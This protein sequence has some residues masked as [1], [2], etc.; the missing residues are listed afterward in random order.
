MQSDDHTVSLSTKHNP[1]CGL[2]CSFT[3]SLLLK[4][5]LTRPAMLTHLSQCKRGSC[6]VIAGQAWQAD[7]VYQRRSVVHG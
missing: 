4:L 6:M 3:C 5:T 2:L 7:V 1:K